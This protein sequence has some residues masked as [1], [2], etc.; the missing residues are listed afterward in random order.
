[1][2]A[3]EERMFL[4]VSFMPENGIMKAMTDNGKAEVPALLEFISTVLDS[5]HCADFLSDGKPDTCFNV[6][7]DGVLVRV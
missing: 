2:E 1:M 7:N 6:E 5:D 3:I 4:S